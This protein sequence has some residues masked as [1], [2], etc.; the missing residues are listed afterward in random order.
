MGIA[1]MCF[2]SRRDKLKGIMV[3]SLFISSCLLLFTQNPV[4][5]LYFWPILTI[6]GLIY[7]LDCI[8]HNKGLLANRD[9]LRMLV[10]GGL[11]VIICTSMLNSLYYL[12]NA[13][14]YYNALSENALKA[15]KWIKN[16]TSNDS[17]IATSGPFKKGSEGAGNIYGWWIEGYSDRKSVA[18]SY[19]RFLIYQDERKIAQEANIIF[20]G[21][22]VL[23]NDYIMIAETTYSS[24]GNPEI[25]V[26]IGDF[27]EKILFFADNETIIT[28][29]NDNSLKNVTLAN[30][31]HKDK[32]ISFSTSK[33][34][35]TITYVSKNKPFNVMKKIGISNI[36]S[37]ANISFNI[38]HE[39][40][41]TKIAI[42]LLLSDFTRLENYELVSDKNIRF[43]LISPV[44]VRV[45]TDLSVETN[46]EE[47]IETF[48]PL[49][50]YKKKTNISYIYF[51][52]S[53]K[54]I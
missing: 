53:S 28:Y 27:Y 37:T 38:I 9:N 4:R 16:E 49:D 35:L 41:L 19:L 7:F 31:E 43:Y 12:Y 17:I 5:W 20:S 24:L 51:L 15:L 21:T 18:T 8:V 52:R 40:N 36:S 42:P 48:F 29:Y 50:P 46:Y 22:D 6:L 47:K 10:I 14:S 11:I 54:G 2:L 32:D 45:E 33:I 25:G 30:L 1:G 44:D 34:E 3:T 26:N 39:G 13:C 23:L